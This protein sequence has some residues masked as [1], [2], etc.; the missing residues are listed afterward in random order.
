M[1]S[2]RIRHQTCVGR[3]ILSHWAPRAAPTA[4]LMTTFDNPAHSSYCP[5]PPVTELGWGDS[6][7]PLH[8][9]S[10]SPRCAAVS[11]LKIKWTTYQRLLRRGRPV[12]SILEGCHPST[13]DIGLYIPE[14]LLFLRKKKSQKLQTKGFTLMICGTRYLKPLPKE[15]SL[16]FGCFNLRASLTQDFF[17]LSRGPQPLGSNGW[18]SAV[19]LRQQW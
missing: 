4:L 13:S 7:S 2:S 17:F 12:L 9:W 16:K 6:M 8:H 19:E 5:F 10:L 1:G 18:W 11:L 15:V 14:A 3:W